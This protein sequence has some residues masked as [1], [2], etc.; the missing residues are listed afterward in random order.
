MWAVRR[1]MSNDKNNCQCIFM[2]DGVIGH[3]SIR[4][5]T[6]SGH[7][8]LLL[9]ISASFGLTSL[10]IPRSEPRYL[11]REE[12][13]FA[14][15]IEHSLNSSSRLSLNIRNFDRYLSWGNVLYLLLQVVLS[16]SK[17][18]WITRLFPALKRLRI[19][20]IKM[21]SLLLLLFILLLILLLLF[22]LLCLLL[23]I[24]LSILLLLLLLLYLLLLLLLF[25]L[26]F[27]LLSILPLLFLLLSLL[28]SLLPSLLVFSLAL[29]LVFFLFRAR[30]ELVYSRF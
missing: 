18:S 9:L 19:R 15:S 10:A 25:V 7:F 22:L 27:I 4:L 2:V 24:L 17:K 12:P 30:F 28:L 21:L 8:S 26:L 1:Y 20:W 23:S 3:Q 5:S 13:V 14:S 11:S 29:K 16:N 6:R